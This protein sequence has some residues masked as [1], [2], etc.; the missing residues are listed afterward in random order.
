MKRKPLSLLFSLCFTASMVS[1]GMNKSGIE[2]NIAEENYICSGLTMDNFDESGAARTALKCKNRQDLLSKF[3]VFV[4]H[5]YNFSDVLPE[6]YLQVHGN[7]S[8]CVVRRIYDDLGNVFSETVCF[9]INDFI[10]ERY[11]YSFNFSQNSN[12]IDFSFHTNIEVDF[13]DL[14]IDSGEIC[15]VLSLINCDGEVLKHF[16]VSYGIDDCANVY[17]AKYEG[18]MYFGLNK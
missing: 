9:I 6:N 14:N 7:A 10:G 8:F 18:H 16:D 1:C 11:L 17:F 2:N 4:G 5:S 15:F 3:E 13:A 12:L